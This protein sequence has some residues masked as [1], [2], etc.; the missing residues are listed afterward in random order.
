MNREEAINLFDGIKNTADQI[1]NEKD[2]NEYILKE[3]NKYSLDQWYEF[4]V[5]LNII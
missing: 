4:G 5:L 1:I 2:R 3:F